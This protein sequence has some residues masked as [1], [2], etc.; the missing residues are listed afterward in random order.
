MGVHEERPEGGWAVSAGGADHPSQPAGEPS[1]VK[2][3]GNIDK[4][5]GSV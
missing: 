3:Y 4:I 5:T 1:R 2:L